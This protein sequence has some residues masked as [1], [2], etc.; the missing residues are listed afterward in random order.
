MLYALAASVAIL[1][2][3]A[4]WLS[5]STGFFLIWA[6]F[7]AWACFFHSGGDANA[8]KTT[9]ISNCF[10]VFV[11]WSA[12]LVIVSIPGDQLLPAPVWAA[13]VVAVSIALYILAAHISLLSGIPAVTYGYAATFAFLT[14]NADALKPMAL[15]SL[16]SRNAILIVPLSMIIG[17]IFAFA[18]A[19]FAS[20]LERRVTATD[21][22]ARPAA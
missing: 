20:F 13:L 1:G 5:L 8:F 22:A 15:L 11:A 21:R 9:V 16:T 6:A 3:I 10:G 7:I 4:T 14:Q 19:K 2:G 12:A 18:S 17:A